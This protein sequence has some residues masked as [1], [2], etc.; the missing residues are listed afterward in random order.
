[1]KVLLTGGAGFIGLRLSQHLAES[2]ANV[3][4]VDRIAPQ[5]SDADFH[6]VIRMKNVKFMAFDALDEINLATLDKDYTHI[7][8]LAAML[9]V[10]NVLSSP[11]EVIECNHRLTYNFLQLAKRQKKKP[12]FIYSSTSEVYAGTLAEGLLVV[13]SP[14]T[15][16]IIL[17][18]IAQA[19]T[20]Y[21]LS[22]LN[23]E[24]LCAYSGIPFTIIRPHNIYGPRMGM[25]HVIPELLERAYNTK[26]NKLM[27]FSPTHTRT[28]CYV[29]DE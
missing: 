18:S 15:S 24:A 6:S 14:E 5:S 11:F 27:V 2:G 8:H 19:R 29:N 3:H 13:P 23:G 25:R 7:V 28:F 26:D 1:M 4:M 22:K 16:Q 20:S 21:M 10:Q 9:G 12:R 17:P